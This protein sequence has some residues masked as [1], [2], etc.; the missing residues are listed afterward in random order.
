MIRKQRERTIKGKLL[1]ADKVLVNQH[2]CRESLRS[3]QTKG[4]FFL[5][6]N[7]KE[8]DAAVRER[9]RVCEW[10]VELIFMDEGLGKMGMFNYGKRTL[11]LALIPY[12]SFPTWTPLPS[13]FDFF[14][15]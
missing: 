15:F 6:G 10:R 14:F 2:V 13:S 11:L 3:I 4:F 9:E 8:R 5:L 7:K 12:K 1:T